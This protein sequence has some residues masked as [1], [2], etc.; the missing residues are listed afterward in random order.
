MGPEET[1]DMVALFRTCELLA[2][3]RRRTTPKS[4]GCSRYPKQLGNCLS[5]IMITRL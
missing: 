3:C 2:V 1:D 4:K 5:M